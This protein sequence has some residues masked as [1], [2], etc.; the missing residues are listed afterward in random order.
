MTD[1]AQAET[2]T[3]STTLDPNDAAAP[4]GGGAPRTL[5]DDKPEPSLRDTIA[6][7]AKESAKEET[8]PDADA[9]KSDDKAEAAKGEEKGAQKPQEGEKAP[10]KG[11]D[12]QK[13]EKAPERAPDGKFAGKQAEGDDTAKADPK[14]SGHID[15]PKNFLPDAKETWRNTPRAV[16]RDVENT[17]RTYEAKLA[18]TSEVAERYAPL[19]EFDELVR[20]NGRA[21]LHETLAEVKQLEDLM[22]RNPIAAVNQIL[23]RAGPRKADGQPVS[24]FELAQHIVNSGQDNYQRAVTMPAQQQQPQEDPRVAQLEAK[25]AEVQTQTLNATVIG[26]FKAEHPRYEELREDIAFFLQ[27]GKIPSSLSPSDRLAAAYDMAVRINPPSHGDEADASL[28]SPEP[29]GRA[30]TDLS[31]SKSIKSAPGAVSADME[32][33]RGGSIRDLLAS[34]LKRAKRS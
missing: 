24:L 29:R 10:A 15:P 26:P 16:Q 12:A 23:L 20:A 14:P 13:A 8:K 5:A 22:E 6:A 28:T 18:E 21:G 4:S 34:E 7:A 11:E 17:I 25:L 1:L 19:R 30:A 33:E 2:P 27:S 3:V 31:G 9:D 32:P